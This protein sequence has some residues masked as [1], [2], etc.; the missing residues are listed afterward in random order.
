MKMKKNKIGK[1]LSEA[2]ATPTESDIYKIVVKQ[3]QKLE[4]PLTNSDIA[5]VHGTWRTNIR[6]H[7]MNLERKELIMRVSH[8]FYVPILKD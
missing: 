5:K 7:L 3:F 1:I 8:K 4:R 6:Y 2:K